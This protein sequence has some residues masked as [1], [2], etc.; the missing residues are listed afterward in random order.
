M[1]ARDRLHFIVR[2]ALEADG[3]TI[4]ADPLSLRLGTRDLYIDLG[5]ERLLAAERDSQKIAVEIKALSGPSPVADLERALGQFV[6]YTDA[7]ELFDPERVLY[8]ALPQTATS[9]LEEPIGQLLLGKGRLRVMLFHTT[10]ER[11]ITWLP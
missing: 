1:P 9:L 8:L 7:L 2:H 6:L 10:E 5:A 3:W 11:I 4:T